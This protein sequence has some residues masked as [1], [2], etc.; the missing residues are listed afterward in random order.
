[1]ISTDQKI[2]AEQV[3]DIL[4]KTLSMRVPSGEEM[5]RM[6]I[7]APPGATVE[8]TMMEVV[9]YKMVLSAARG[10]SRAITEIFDRLIGKSVQKQEVAHQ[11]N[12][13]GFLDELPIPHQNKPKQLEAET[14][15]ALT[16]EG[17]RIL[18]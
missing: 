14:T 13:S 1:M 18:G 17:E 11:L 3:T 2:A 8:T 16:A 7:Q 6:G 9:V 10:N 5:E 4:A 12:Y 15:L